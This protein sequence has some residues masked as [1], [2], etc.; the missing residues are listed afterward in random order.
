MMTVPIDTSEVI[1][2]T[3]SWLNV[4]IVGRVVTIKRT[5]RKLADVIQTLV[6]IAVLV[7]GLSLYLIWKLADRIGG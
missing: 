1:F 5:R 4:F 6:A 2:F 3:R 7:L